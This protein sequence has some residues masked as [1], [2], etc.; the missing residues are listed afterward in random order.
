MDLQ[1][2]TNWLKTTV[3]G[4][5]I[6]GSVGSLLAVLVLWLLSRFTPVFVAAGRGVRKAH[7]KMMFFANKITHRRLLLDR[8]F[9]EDSIEKGNF[10][11]LL[12]FLGFRLLRV[13]AV[14][15]FICWACL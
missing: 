7:E 9:L 12:F 14:A 15:S 10:L 6:L 8:V 2:V 3:P 4:I 11:G 13:L 1:N 5:I